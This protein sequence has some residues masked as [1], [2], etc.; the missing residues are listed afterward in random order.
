MMPL[1]V[2]LHRARLVPGQVTILWQVNHV[3]AEP[4]TQLY[5]ACPSLHG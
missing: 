1:T 3:S 5:S 2:V 4:A